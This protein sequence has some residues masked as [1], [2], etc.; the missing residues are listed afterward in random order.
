MPSAMPRNSDSDPSVTMSGGMS[1]RAMS[2]ALSAPPA[3][4]TSS[5]SAAATGSGSC[6]SL[7]AAPN[8]TA[9]RPDHRADRQIDAAGDDDRR[10]R[11]RQQAK[12]DAQPGDLEEVADA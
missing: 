7:A 10:Q 1:S 12:L 4:P 6:Q 8:T 5:A 2:S 11:D 3:A 9:D